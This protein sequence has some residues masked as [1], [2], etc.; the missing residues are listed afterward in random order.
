M[1]YKSFITSLP[2]ILGENGILK[3]CFYESNRFDPVNVAVS[4]KDV[5]VPGQYSLL[6][7]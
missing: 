6:T 1:L 3:Q 7:K 2:L 4:T 5:G